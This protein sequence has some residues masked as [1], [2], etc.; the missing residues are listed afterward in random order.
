MGLGSVNLKKIYS[1]DLRMYSMQQ[2]HPYSPITTS[3]IT[4]THISSLETL[5]LF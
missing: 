4:S 5:T 1:Q 2:P 3:V